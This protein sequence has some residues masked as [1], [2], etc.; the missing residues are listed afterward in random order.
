MVL[1]INLAVGTKLLACGRKPSCALPAGNASLEISRT[2]A[3]IRAGTDLITGY[4]LHESPYTLEINPVL[5]NKSSQT[6][7]PYDIVS[8]SNNGSYSAGME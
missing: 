5:F 8:R 1:S 7:K 6:L 3:T 4:E 2:T